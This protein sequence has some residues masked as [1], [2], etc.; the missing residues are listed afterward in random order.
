MISCMPEDK[1]SEILLETS[2]YA[3]STLIYLVD[4]ETTV[5][6]DSGYIVDNRLVFNVEVVEPTRLMIRPVFETREDFQVRYIWKETSKLTVRAEKGNLKNAVVEGSVIQIQADLVK[7]S[8]DKLNMLNDS[9]IKVY[10]SMEDRSSEEAKAIRARGRGIAKEIAAVDV[11]YIK[12]N[13][14]NIYSA[15][16]L[17][18]LMTYTIPKAETEALYEN[19]SEEVKSTKYGISIKN[20]LELSRDLKAGDRA[21][22]FKMPDINGEMVALSDFKGKYILLDFWSSGCGPCRMESPN[23]LRNYNEYRDKGFEIISITFDRDRDVWEKAVRKD[24]MIWTTLFDHKGSDGD[25]IMT[26]NVYF[27]PTYFLIDPDGIIIDTWK[28]T[29]QLDGKLTDVFTKK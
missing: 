1:K 3:D 19:L 11:N 23:L 10:N 29:G 17:K 26:Y 15:I 13:P 7:A 2:G 9:L 4:T 5:D 20:Y 24:G 21:V 12:N 8:K 27:M 22:D 16:T 25:A 28:G 14:D 18:Q 6:I